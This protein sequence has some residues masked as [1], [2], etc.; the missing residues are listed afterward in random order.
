MARQM[1]L[2]ATTSFWHKLK[3]MDWILV[4]LIGAVATVGF[5]SLYAAA[6]GNFNPWA[7]RQM[8]RF[9]IGLALMFG[10][11]LI[12]IRFWLKVSYFC[13]AGGLLLLILVEIAGHI[14]MGAQRW[15]DLGFMKL[16]PSELMKIGVVMALARYFHTATADEMK[17]LLYLLPAALIILAPV[18]LVL[19]QPDLGTSL[20]IV[21]AGV[22][23]LFVVGAPLWIFLGGIGL[24]VVS[25]PVL[26]HFMH[27]YQRQRVLTFLNPESDPL[28]AG[29]HITQ[30]KI[31]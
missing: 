18:G 21:M 2:T 19:L 17:R 16:Q 25:I 13:F 28:G 29:Y 1:D 3:N 6:N 11:A 4:L 30:S 9:M 31:A 23:V 22:S 15:I 24:T 12:D 27:D 10:I 8:A 14:G 5:L 26:W 7:S 20:M